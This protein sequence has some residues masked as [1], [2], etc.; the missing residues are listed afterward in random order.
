MSLLGPSATGGLAHVNLNLLE[1]KCLNFHQQGRHLWHAEVT[2]SS[3]GRVNPLRSGG[4]SRKASLTPP[5]G[6]WRG[7]RARLRGSCPGSAAPSASCPHTSAPAR[8]P[9]S[10][11]VPARPAAAA[12]RR[13]QSLVS[14]HTISRALPI[15]ASAS[16]EC[17][18]RSAGR[19]THLWGGKNGLGVPGPTG[20]DL[21]LHLPPAGSLKRLQGAKGAAQHAR[22]LLR[23]VPDRAALFVLPLGR[24]LGGAPA[25]T[26]RRPWRRPST[27]AAAPH[28]DDLQHRLSPA[29]SQV[30][31]PATEAGLPEQL[32]QRGD[33]PGRQVLNLQ[34][35]KGRQGLG[36]RQGQTSAAPSSRSAQPPPLPPQGSA[37]PCAPRPASGETQKTTPP[38]PLT[39]R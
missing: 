9:P 5:A 33:V 4:L 12:S 39:W 16:A 7:R 13:G 14:T 20:G 1:F 23:H 26:E 3:N 24:R 18:G 25:A 35:G 31:G 15:G 22:E 37:R 36:V 10:N 11:P 32:P 28:L 6:P 19:A 38:P 29:G 34:A 21:A 30:P 17:R 2:D 27:A 8:A